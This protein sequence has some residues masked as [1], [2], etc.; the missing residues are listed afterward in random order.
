MYAAFQVHAL[1]RAQP[2]QATINDQTPGIIAALTT[3]P[4][5]DHDTA[6]PPNVKLADCRYTSA[7]SSRKQCVL[8]NPLCAPVPAFSA[9]AARYDRRE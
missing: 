3:D 1:Y 4:R 9:V 5:T 2:H 7:K 6:D 8:T